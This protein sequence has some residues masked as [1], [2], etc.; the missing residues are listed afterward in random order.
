MRKFPCSCLTVTM[1]ASRNL[2]LAVYSFFGD[3][4][5]HQNTYMK[6]FRSSVDISSP[7]EIAWESCNRLV[8]RHSAPE[9]F[10]HWS[11]E[12]GSEFLGDRRVL[13][14]IHL[15]TWDYQDLVSG[16]QT[17]PLIPTPSSQVTRRHYM[18]WVDI[19]VFSRHFI[20]SGNCM[21]ILQS[22]G[23]SSLRRPSGDQWVLGRW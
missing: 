6:T 21:K 20:C 16:D 7:L 23:Q 1:Y 2:G 17:W 19:Q 5:S 11:S 10:D 14:K 15:M 22:S 4:S 3:F 13:P 8:N 18:P 9:T 12:D